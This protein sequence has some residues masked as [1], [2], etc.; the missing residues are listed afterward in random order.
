MGEELLV[1]F[2]RGG[3]VTRGKNET[4]G[5]GAN[6]GRF[7]RLKMIGQNQN[8]PLGASFFFFALL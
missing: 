2:V 3:G 5:R 8:G 6:E 1:N 7:F 4:F